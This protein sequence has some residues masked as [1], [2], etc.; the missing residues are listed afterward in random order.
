MKS[1]LLFKIFTF[2]ATCVISITQC[3]AQE[4][5]QLLLVKN[6]ET[7]QLC[8]DVALKYE[9]NNKIMIASQNYRFFYSSAT[10]EYD[11][12]TSV[13]LLPEETYTYKLV[14]HK[15]HVNGSS[16]GQ[17]SFDQDLGFINTSVI[18]NST[19]S[20]GAGLDRLAPELKL[21]RLCFNDVGEGDRHILPARQGLTKDYGRAYVDVS[22]VGEGGRISSLEFSSYKDILIKE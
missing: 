4:S 7:S 3:V 9:G 5:A 14:Q 10:L 16:I 15:N 20:L 6:T 18:L 12:K 17:L 8:Y 19:N 13:L 21:L 22:Y 1:N 2:C 11:E